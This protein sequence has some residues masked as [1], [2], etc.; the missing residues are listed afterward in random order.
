M[1]ITNI[2]MMTATVSAATEDRRRRVHG[3]AHLLCFACGE[4]AGGGLGL[5][6]HVEDDGVVATDWNCPATYQ[7][8]AGVLHGGVIATLLDSA[9]VHALFARGI[10]ARTAELRVRYRHPVRTDESVVITARLGTQI[11]PLYVLDANLGQHGTV[12]A[13]ARAKFMAGAD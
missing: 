1:P 12:C 9:M 10:A 2:R 4:S 8:Y 5:R 6:F 11:G 3:R 7:G 13:T